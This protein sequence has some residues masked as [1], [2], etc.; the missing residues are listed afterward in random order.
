MFE[1]ARLRVSVSQSVSPVSISVAVVDL[2]S[3]DSIQ[4]DWHVNKAALSLK[5]RLSI[6]GLQFA[7]LLA[8]LIGRP[9]RGQNTDLAIDIL[10][11]GCKVPLWLAE[12]FA[13][14][15]Q[16]SF[17]RLRIKAK[18]V[19]ALAIM[20]KRLPFRL[21]HAYVQPERYHCDHRYQPQWKRTFAPLSCSNLL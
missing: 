7:T 17:P 19:A 15:M 1:A 14:D 8:R 6:V 4:D 20:D 11:T 13:I 12:Q 18:Q 16:K 9:C 2:Y 10:M 3:T 21:W 5:H